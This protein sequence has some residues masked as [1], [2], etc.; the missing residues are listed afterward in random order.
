MGVERRM[1][2]K[3]N[4]EELEKLCIICGN[5]LPYQHEKYCSRTC[6]AVY[7]TKPKEKHKCLSCGKETKNPKFCNPKC[8]GKNSKRKK[9]KRFCRMCGNETENPVYCSHKCLFKFQKGDN[10][11]FSGKHHKKKTKKRMSIKH[12]EICNKPEVIE[13]LKLKGLE[14]FSDP[15]EIECA[16]ERSLEYNKNHPATKE[17][18]DR[19]SKNKKLFNKEHPEVAKETGRKIHQFYIDHP[20]KR[21]G[22][23]GE[24]SPRYIKDRSKLKSASMNKVDPTLL[25]NWR[26][27]VYKRD[28]F[29]CQHCGQIGG[30]LNAHH[31][32]DA[33]HYPELILILENGITLCY[34]CHK[35]TDTWG[36]KNKK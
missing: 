6:K 34:E 13:N 26:K 35:K 22:I 9:E 27:E 7:E 2:K 11:P 24:N 18:R 12:K 10:H 19:Q 20:E 36:W 30:K 16:R 3:N 25:N 15:K 4:K 23:S 31:I 33:K 17:Y 21:I 32:K 14:R 8:H 29:T 5:A 28:N 1:K